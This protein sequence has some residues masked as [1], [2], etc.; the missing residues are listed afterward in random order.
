MLPRLSRS[1]VLAA[2]R[3]FDTELRATEAWAGWENNRAHR[4]AIEHEGQRYPVK[5]IAAL[6]SRLPTSAFSGGEALNT[7]V[8]RLGFAIVALQPASGPLKAPAESAM[9][10]QQRIEALEHDFAAARL[11]AITEQARLRLTLIALAE[12]REYARHAAGC[13]VSPCTCGYVVADARATEITALASGE[14]S[15]TTVLTA[16]HQAHQAQEPDADD[17]IA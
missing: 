10:L 9:D 8:A 13:P 12:T 11:L 7:R 3:Q 17:V 15:L 4:W 5:Q 16:L 14:P 2:I 1:A 6:A